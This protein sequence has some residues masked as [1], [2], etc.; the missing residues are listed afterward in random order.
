[1]LTFANRNSKKSTMTV[2]DLKTQLDSLIQSGKVSEDSEVVIGH[3]TTGKEGL[4]GDLYYWGLDYDIRAEEISKPE[5]ERK[6]F[7]EI[8][9]YEEPLR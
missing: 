8:L 7:L 6:N 1:M 3:Y 2:K 5:A 4:I 9:A